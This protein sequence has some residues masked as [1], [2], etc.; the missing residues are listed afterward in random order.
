[1]TILIQTEF[2]LAN[3]TNGTEIEEPKTLP[4]KDEKVV[5]EIWQEDI[6]EVVVRKQRGTKENAGAS[7]KKREKTHIRTTRV[8]KT[9]LKTEHIKSD[10]YSESFST[11]SSAPNGKHHQKHKKMN[12]LKKHTN[13]SGPTTPITTLKPIKESKYYNFFILLLFYLSLHIVIIIK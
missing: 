8:P 7:G 2:S 10:S 6:H 1:M 12:H 11:Q 5:N 13:S 9:N 4:L 3:V